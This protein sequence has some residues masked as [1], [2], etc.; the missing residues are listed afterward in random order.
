MGPKPLVTP[1]NYGS[2]KDPCTASPAAQDTPA[3]VASLPPLP[4]L[5]L[6]RWAE[7][8][9]LRYGNRRRS[10][11]SRLVGFLDQSECAAII[12]RLRHIQRRMDLHRGIERYPAKLLEHWKGNNGCIAR[13]IPTEFAFEAC[14]LSE[15]VRRQ[16]ALIARFQPL[17]QLKADNNGIHRLVQLRLHGQEPR[18]RQSCGY[19][20]SALILSLNEPYYRDGHLYGDL[21]QQ[22]VKLDGETVTLTPMQYEV[23]S[24]MV[25][26]AGEVVPRAA[27]LRQI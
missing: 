7:K 23:L 13:A 11:G 22:V 9:P 19:R 24:L 17:L 15:R 3:P 16:A 20:G 5:L 8:Y 10:I 12:R 25:R 14:N 18:Q 4:G 1:D 26:H 21:R 6:Q 2:P 27:F